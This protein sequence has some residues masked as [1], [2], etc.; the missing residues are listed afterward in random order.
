M[1]N[2]MLKKFLNILFV[3]LMFFIGSSSALALTGIVNVNDSLTLR[4]SPSTSGNKITSF[5]NNTEVVVLE[6]NAGQVKKN[7]IQLGDKVVHT[8]F[9]SQLPS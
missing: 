5:Y 6:I 3:F 2:I 8:L 9:N 4:D 1:N 7:N